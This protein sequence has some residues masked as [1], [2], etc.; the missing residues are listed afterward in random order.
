MRMRYTASNIPILKNRTVFFDANSLIYIF[1]PTTP[2]SKAA[3]DYGSILATLM[4]NNVNLAINEIVL[5]EIINRVLRTEFNKTNLPK[6]KFKD[7]R[8]SAEG[9]SVQEDIYKIIKNRIL[10]IFQITNESFSREDF[11]SMLTTSKLDFNDKLIE[12]LCK[13]KNMLLLT[14]DFDFASSDVDILSANRKF[15]SR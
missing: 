1:W 12:L 2:D 9:K 11:S 8:D 3:N 10:N 6:E 7:F 14:H 4:K 13:K 5:S 15:K